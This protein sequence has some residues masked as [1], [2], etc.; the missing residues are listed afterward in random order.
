MA[1]RFVPEK[2]G[3]PGKFT[4]KIHKFAENIAGPRARARERAMA[5]AAGSVGAEWHATCLFILQVSTS[6]IDL[7]GAKR[8]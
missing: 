8:S 4:G 5:G 3:D 6:V 7:R 2:S 1:T